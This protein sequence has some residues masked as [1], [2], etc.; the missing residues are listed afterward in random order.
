MFDAQ[1]LAR[2][3]EVVRRHVPVTP[4]Y[5]WP[6]LAE[7]TGAH[8]W[9]KHENHTP[10]GAFKVRGGLV[11]ADELVAG[12]F[13]GSLVSATRGNHGQSL[14]YAA[15]AYG[16][17]ATIVVPEGNDPDQNAAMRAFGARVVVHGHDFQASR[18]HAAA[19]AEQTGGL[20]VQ[21][22][23]PALVRGVATYAAELF[24]AVAAAGV[25]LRTV[26]VPIGMGSGASGVIGVRDLLGLDT[27]VVG[28]V[29]SGAP[30]YALSLAAGHVVSTNTAVT[31]ADG[32]ATRSPDPL[33]FS[34]IAAGIARIVQVDDDAVRRAVRLLYD[35]THQVAEGAGAIALAGLVAE[36]EATPG[37]HQGA[38]VGIVLSGSNLSAPRLAEILA[39]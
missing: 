26:F 22:Y 14:S 20:L 37:R 33:A 30:A 3:T 38:D 27:E 36:I 12:G 17:E 13:S 21:P 5:A 28:V 35:G 31:I 8:V 6:R 7:A 11:L 19:L 23:Q 32:V 25:R 34:V 24:D 2:A 15:R 18:E 39:R 4:T 10:T 9:V 1:E 16:L 29:S